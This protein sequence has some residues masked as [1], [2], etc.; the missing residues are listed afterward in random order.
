[1]V[2]RQN[3]YAQSLGWLKLSF[4]QTDGDLAEVPMDVMLSS[5][6]ALSRTVHLLLGAFENPP[7]S[8]LGG[9]SELRRNFDSRFQLSFAH[10]EGG[11]FA[12]PVRLKLKEQLRET[13]LFS[14]DGVHK[15]VQEFKEY[16]DGALIEAVQ[17]DVS[18]FET[19]F[20]NESNAHRV[21]KE[22][23]GILPKHGLNVAISSDTYRNGHILDSKRHRQTIEAHVDSIAASLPVREKKT[24]RMS[25]VAELEALDTQKRTYR[26]RTYNG[27]EISGNIDHHLSEAEVTFSPKIIELDGD[28][29]VDEDGSIESAQEIYGSARID[30]SVLK[31]AE[32]LAG[33]E[34]LQAVPE[35]EYK[36]KFHTSDLIYYLEGDFDLRLH[37]FSRRELEELLYETLSDWWVEYA[38]EDDTKLSSGARKLKAE[39]TSRFKQ[40]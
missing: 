20:P 4:D 23:S 10:T 40:V 17:E 26:A 27:V 37:A 22:I 3:T 34:R 33:N 18:G 12:I 25:L 35:L 2:S 16:F 11:S 6:T 1:M 7:F 14:K 15:G 13:E 21:V 39:L 38:L 30:S 19:L 28:F 31:V 24:E 29:E 5:F 32:I 9:F 8:P 36:V